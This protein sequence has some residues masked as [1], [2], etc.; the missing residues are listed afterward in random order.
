MYVRKKK[1][2]F[3]ITIMENDSKKNAVDF[4]YYEHKQLSIITNST[5]ELLFAFCTYTFSMVN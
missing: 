3:Y 1:T 5:I 4:A 2:K